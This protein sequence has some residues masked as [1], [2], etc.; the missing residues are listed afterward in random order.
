MGSLRRQSSGVAGAPLNA[1][2]TS[3]RSVTLVLP[4]DPLAA[5]GGYEY[6]RR[7]MQGL[8]NLGWNTQVVTLDNSFPFPTAD[9]L[10]E[11][12]RKLAALPARS[13]VMVD[14]LALGAMPD[15]VHAHRDRLRMVG[16]VH[17]PLAAETGLSPEVAAGLFESERRALQAVR[18]VVVTSLATRRALAAYGVEPDRMA[19]A[20]PGI[21]HPAGAGFG[22]N[23]YGISLPVRMLCVATITPRKGHELLLDAL[24]GVDHLDWTLTCAGN[25]ERS[26]ATARALSMRIEAAG[27][28]D[29]VELTG[30]L[31]EAALQQQFRSA[32][33]FVLATHFEGYGMAV[34]QALAYGLPVV[35]T[36]T[37]AIADLVPPDAGVLVEP[38]DEA[39][40]R[41]A[42]SR[43][44][45]DPDLRRKL[46]EGARVAGSRLP[47]WNVASQRL[48]EILSRV[49]VHSDDDG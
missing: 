8:R 43:V 45:Q 7:M 32:H 20:E 47:S 23:F 25:L 40:L 15:V 42:L 16:L 28:K 37:G 24:A 34:A 44:L 1:S 33:L 30:E 35:S 39:A 4:G 12:E 29:R 3:E 5:T 14:G 6:D 31:D 46:A 9:A 22:G 19:V 17:H 36:R 11:A 49:T 21:D 41:A 10:L 13:L 18:F 2:A 26:P 38:G 27:W 48:S